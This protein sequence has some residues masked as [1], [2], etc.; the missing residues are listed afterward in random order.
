[1]NDLWSSGVTSILT[2]MIVVVG[3]VLLFR[4]KRTIPAFIMVV[5]SVAT[6]VLYLLGL[7]WY[8]EFLSASWL[9]YIDPTTAV[10]PRRHQPRGLQA[11]R[12]DR[13]TGRAGSTASIPHSSIPRRAGI[14][15][16]VPCRGGAEGSSASFSTA[17]CRRHMCAPKRRDD[18]SNQFGA[19][20][21]SS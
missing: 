1:M 4:A 3:C 6:F 20:I 10:A 5:G 9:Y 17:L 16:E 15:F 21:V 19:R 12:A 13:S 8:L 14:A 2:Q 18:P 11:A 7:A